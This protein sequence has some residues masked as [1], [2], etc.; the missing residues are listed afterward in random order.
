MMTP[1]TMAANID[2]VA[3]KL[4]LAM[5]SRLLASWLRGRDGHRHSQVVAKT[6]LLHVGAESAAHDETVVDGGRP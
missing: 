6:S 4:C 3:I 2:S 5:Y 1:T